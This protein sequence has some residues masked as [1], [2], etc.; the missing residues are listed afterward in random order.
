MT[1]P[2]NTKT[3]NLK[4]S[5]P[6]ASCPF[7][8]T[9]NARYPQKE[10]L[11]NLDTVISQFKIHSFIPPLTISIIYNRRLSDYQQCSTQSFLTQLLPE[12]CVYVDRTIARRADR[13]HES[14]KFSTIAFSS[15]GETIEKSGEDISRLD[16]H[17]VIFVGDCEFAIYRIDPGPRVYDD[18]N[19]RQAGVPSVRVTKSVMFEN[20]PSSCTPLGLR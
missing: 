4:P 11:P 15:Y 18:G 5:S 12:P 8:A 7:R 14:V 17:A 19:V 2:S 20:G 10:A 16:A 13:V 1:Q 9:G 3:I 6:G